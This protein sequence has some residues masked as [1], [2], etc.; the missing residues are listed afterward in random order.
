MRLRIWS[1]AGSAKTSDDEARLAGSPLALH[2]KVLAEIEA[3]DV[4]VRNDFVWRP[5]G[6]NVAAVNDVS[7]IDQPEGFAHIVVGNQDADASPFEV[8]HEV[9]DVAD[10]DRVDAGEQ[11]VQEHERRFAGKGPGDLASPP[12]AA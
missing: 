1:Q 2:L 5:L 9:L 12:F 3:S 10:R 7:P 8:T 11:F 6:Q 4:R